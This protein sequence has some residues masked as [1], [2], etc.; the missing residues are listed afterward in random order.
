MQVLRVGYTLELLGI[1]EFIQEKLSQKTCLLNST[2]DEVK[3]SMTLPIVSVLKNKIKKHPLLLTLLAAGLLIA[4][5]SATYWTLTQRQTPS[6]GLPVG[7]NIIPQ[8]ALFT[9]SLTTDAQEWQKL[10]KLGTKQTQAAINKNLVQLRDRLLNSNGYDFEKDIAPWVGNQVTLAILSPSTTQP[11]LKPAEKNKD[12]TSPQQS[13]VMVLPVNN[14]AAA[15]NIFTAPKTLKPGKWSDRTYQGIT[16]KQIDS[17]SGEKLSAALLDQQFL[18]ITDH[19]QATERAIDTYQGK[20]SLAT[21]AGF[22]EHFRKIFNPRSFA[23]FYVNVPIAAKLAAAAPNRALPDQV[24]A[25]LQNNQGLAGSITLEPEGI[26]LTGISWR[27][28][29]SQRLLK[30]ENKAGTMQNRVPADTLM[31]LSGGNLK[32]WWEDYVS[33]SQKNPLSPISPEQLRGGVKSLTELDLDRDFLSWM[34]GE[35]SVSV[36]PNTGNNDSAQ[37]FRAGLLFLVQAKDSSNGKSLRRKA[38]ASLKKLDEVM[39]NQYQFQIQPSRVAGQQVVNWMTPFNTLTA[40]R[41]WLDDDIAFLVV[42]APITDK[43]LPKPDQ[44]LASTLPFQQT[45]P[46]E[47]NPSNGQFF[48]DMETAVK[49]FTLSSLFPNQQTFLDATRSIG[50]TSAVSDN[51]STRYNIFIVLK[52]SNSSAVAPFPPLSAESV[53]QKLN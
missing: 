34:Q 13:M 51:R 17:P 27:N 50:V 53:M 3:V 16:I 48:L 49:N 35:F 8:D 14:P 39:K 44:T 19:P 11:A 23:Q 42:G 4:G 47:P 1:D 18:V 7:A 20:T 12:A 33:T 9:L 24:L 10:Q 45:V 28:S 31:M 40:S 52:K 15:K 43:I 46:T 32:Q 41:G 38:E 22:G 37:D 25:Q 30:V 21:V 5:G 26:R 2:N 29:H 36:I 6:Q